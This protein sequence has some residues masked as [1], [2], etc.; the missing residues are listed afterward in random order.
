MQLPCWLG[1]KS[2]PPLIISID[3]ASSSARPLKAKPHFLGRLKLMKVISVADAKARE[4]E[5]LSARFLF[6]AC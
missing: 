5:A 6:L 2:L 1:V 3:F 4:A